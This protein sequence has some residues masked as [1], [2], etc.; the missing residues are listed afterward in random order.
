MSQARYPVRVVP[1]DALRE[2]EYLGTKFKF[3]FAPPEQPKA[4]VL[5]KRGRENEDW[6]EKVATTIGHRLGLPAAEVDL[7]TLDGTPG[8]VSPSF[9]EPGDTLFHGNELLLQVLDGYE[10]GRRYHV[11]EHT[12]EAVFAALEAVGARPHPAQ[13]APF[14]G[15]TAADQFVGYLLLDALVANT[16]RHHENWGVLQRGPD[17]LLAP[18]YDHASSLGRNERE[19]RIQRRLSGDD[20]RVTVE[21]WVERGRSAFYAPTAAPGV[22]KPL[23]PLH[24][25]ARAAQLRPAGAEFW[26]SQLE[27]LREE[28][29]TEALARVPAE[30]ISDLHREFAARILICNRGRVRRM[31]ELR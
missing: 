17:R 31:Q 4:R 14:S 12:V 13:E 3:W 5:F 22:R 2:D 9:L 7:A 24:A 8:I 10:S 16:D 23:S 29:L 28:A 21:A 11:A 6:S 27:A 15:F 18:T 25:F 19:A 30:R 1:A 20:P 26:L